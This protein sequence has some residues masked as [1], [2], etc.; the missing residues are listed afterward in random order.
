MDGVAPT[1][2]SP[3]D[4]ETSSTEADLS[5]STNEG[6]GTLYWYVSTSATPPSATDLK[7]GTGAVDSGSQ[8]VSGTGVQNATANGLTA[9]TTY[10][11]H[12][13]HRDATG[14]DSDIA[15]GDGFTTEATP[16]FTPL[17]DFS[18]E[19]NSQLLALLED[20]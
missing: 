8:T 5:V 2:S 19:R 12:F 11:A 9:E 7:A 13:L 20:F 17:M 10:Y 1:L 18:D 6:N 3:T 15:S 16:S 4:V 14:N